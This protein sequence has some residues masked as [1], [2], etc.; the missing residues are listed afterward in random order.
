MPLLRMQGV[1]KSFGATRALRD[2]SLS[3]EAGES[4]ALIGENGAGKST[5]MKILSGAVQPDAGEFEFAGRP[6]APNGPAAAR[7]AG[8]AMIYQELSLAPDLSVED[9]ILLGR[10]VHRGGILNRSAQR[11]IVQAAL[12]TLGHGDL[13]PETLVRDLSPGV[14]QLVEIAR[15][16]AA[17]ARVIVFDEPTSSLTRHDVERLFTVIDKIRARGIAVIYI[18]HF[19]EEVRRVCER[20][21]VL[22][23]GA[24]AGSGS[25][26][27][28]SEAQIVALMVGRSVQELFPSVPHQPGE[29]VRVR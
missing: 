21:T 4:L 13:R 24:V 10:E 3:V 6:F 19:L 2:V 1:S 18:S 16:I 7:R 14:R 20:Y 15:A 29:P 5:L 28:V 22:R 11:R 26:T 8:V 23:D 9:N 17:D 12:E 27:G 25:L